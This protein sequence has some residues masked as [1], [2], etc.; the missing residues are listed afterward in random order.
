[1]A[2]TGFGDPERI[3]LLTTLK[4][5]LNDENVT[6]AVWA[7]L[8]VSHI[9]KLRNLVDD[10]QRL[11]AVRLGLL[12]RATDRNILR[13]CEF[14]DF[15]TCSLCRF[16]NVIEGPND[17][18]KCLLRGHHLRDQQ[19]HSQHLRQLL[20]QNWQLHRVP[21]FPMALT[22]RK[23]RMDNQ[24]VLFVALKRSENWLVFDE[25]QSSS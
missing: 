4:R 20:Y 13:L 6:S 12:N 15:C 23:T 1:M 11:T 10:A 24:R 17:I 25:F 3:S 14:L 22:G 21:R 16:A 9:G 18:A 2:D 7:S 5:V 19:L 8:W